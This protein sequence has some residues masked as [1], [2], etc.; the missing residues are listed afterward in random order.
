MTDLPVSVSVAGNLRRALQQTDE[1][2][3]AQLAWFGTPYAVLFY[4]LL[5]LAFLFV[6]LH[7]LPD[8]LRAREKKR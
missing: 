5:A 7:F 1:G 3:L 4:I 8:Y 2:G 6:L